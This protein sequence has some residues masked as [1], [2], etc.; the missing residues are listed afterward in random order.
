VEISIEVL[1]CYSFH[2]TSVKDPWFFVKGKK[3]WE[4]WEEILPRYQDKANTF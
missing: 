4:S 3:K 2:L 1:M